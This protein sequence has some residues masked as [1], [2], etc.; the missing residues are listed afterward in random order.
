MIALTDNQ[1]EHPS[2]HHSVDQ[3]VAVYLLAHIMIGEEAQRYPGT[4]R[5]YH[6]K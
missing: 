1:S 5:D 3:S 4:Y 6:Y 2:T